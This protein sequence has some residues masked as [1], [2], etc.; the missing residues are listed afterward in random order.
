VAWI[1]RD[2]GDASGFAAGIAACLL[3]SCRAAI[4]ARGRA[5]LVLAGGRTPFAAYRAFAASDLP[6]SRVHVI[7]TDERCVPHEHAACNT[8]ELRLALEAARGIDITALTPAD[9]DPARSEAHARALLAHTPEA[10]DLVLLGM[11][12]DAH[13]ASLFPGSAA[14]PSALADG[15]A[16]AYRVDPVPLP[17]EAPY[18]RVSLSL[19]RLLRTRCLHLALTGETKRAVLQMAQASHDPMRQPISAVL[20]AAQPPLTIHWSP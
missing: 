15:S 3:D 7:A 17:P 6:W 2:Y 13:T 20:H 9:G 4:A 16:D 19:A 10:F 12:T 1:E 5:I 14:L 8:R 11:G 18:P